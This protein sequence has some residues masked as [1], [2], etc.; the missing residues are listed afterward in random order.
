GR[1]RQAV[2]SGL[3]RDKRRLDDLCDLADAGQDLG[4][5]GRRRAAVVRAGAVA[6]L[7]KA[8]QGAPPLPW[9]ALN[10]VAF[11]LWPGWPNPDNVVMNAWGHWGNGHFQG[12]G[13]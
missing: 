13:R 1:E 12:D 3:V 2:A 6:R 7:F 10:H 4:R 9:R 11:R 8:G 5:E